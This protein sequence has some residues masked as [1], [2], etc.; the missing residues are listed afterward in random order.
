MLTFPLKYM[1][2]VDKELEI[3]ST[4]VIF[5]SKKKQ[6]QQNSIGAQTTWVFHCRGD[7]TQRKTLENFYLNIN[8]NVQPFY[9]TDEDGVQ[10]T[11][12]LVDPKFKY[13]LLR[14]FTYNNTGGTVV[15]FTA[16]ITVEK[17]L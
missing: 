15:G 12:R 10:Q 4:T 14:E 17:V 11:V 2:D 8:G 9:F 6:V 13:K 1:F 5:A 7:N 16:D 3:A